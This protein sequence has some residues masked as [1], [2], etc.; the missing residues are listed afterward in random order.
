[1]TNLIDAQA[2]P[3]VEAITKW[4]KAEIWFI[5]PIVVP[6]FLICLVVARAAYLAFS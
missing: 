5:P 2:T 1:M 6:A 4:K 3:P